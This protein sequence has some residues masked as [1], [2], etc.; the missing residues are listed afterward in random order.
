MSRDLNRPRLGRGLSS[1]IRN[2][3][4]EAPVGTAAGTEHGHYIP[5]NPD[6]GLQPA[7]AAVPGSAIGQ[8]AYAA[9]PALDV[10]PPAAGLVLPI[11][12]EAILKL[13]VAE[14]LP[15]PY[16]P[17]RD[18]DEIALAELV[19]SIRVHGLLE[20]IVVASQPDEDG[21][22]AARYFV[23]AGE[24]RLRASQVAG[25]ETI[26]CVLRQATRQ[27]MLELAII[28]NIHRSDLNPMERAV[29]YRD[30][31]DQFGLTQNQVAERV[32]EPRSAVANYLRL[33]DL[34]DAV[35]E[36]IRQGTLNMGQ[37]KVMAALAGR[38]KVQ[39]DLAIRCIRESLSVRQLEELVKLAIEGRAVGD[40][41]PAPSTAGRPAAR[42]PYIGDLERQL[43]EA[44]GTRVA[45]RPGRGK[46]SGRIMIDYYSLEDFDRLVAALGAKLES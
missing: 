40:A 22:G 29:A 9:V 41:G 13:K 45:I 8:A 16:Q 27:E 4:A 12:G 20:P 17:R 35:Q 38:D 18:F 10:A 5:A 42:A 46:H 31:M 7:A 33:L 15:N 11:P 25:L 26:P 2:S 39:A 21:D 14:I 6:I 30:L 1:L 34:C 44:V 23:I 43:T 24:R 28:E 19:E 3:S 36:H 32:G 37:G